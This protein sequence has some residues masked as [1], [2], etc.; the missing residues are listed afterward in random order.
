MLRIM[1]YRYGIKYY[2][3][4]LL[5]RYAEKRK[6]A[7]PTFVLC[8]VKLP[9]R[10]VTFVVY[11]AYTRINCQHLILQRSEVTERRL[12]DRLVY[13]VLQECS[14]RMCTYICRGTI[15]MHAVCNIYP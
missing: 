10:R 13:V 4:N 7:P 3:I 6:R 8:I 9:L 2:L 12:V 1:I 11:G 14:A 15:S 5:D